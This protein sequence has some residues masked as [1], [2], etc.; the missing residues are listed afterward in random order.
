MNTNLERRNE[1][2][3]LWQPML[4]GGLM[5]AVFTALTEPANP[6]VILPTPTPEREMR[7]E[8]WDCDNYTHA[9]MDMQHNPEHPAYYAFQRLQFACTQNQATLALMQIWESDPLA[10]VVDEPVP[11]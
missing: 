10:G 5:M 1:M 4:A 9:P 2:A 7:V 11:E 3:R 8:V 6:P